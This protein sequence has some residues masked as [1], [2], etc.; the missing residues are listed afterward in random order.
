M[1][2]SSKPFLL[3]KTFGIF[4]IFPNEYQNRTILLKMTD[5]KKHIKAYLKKNLLSK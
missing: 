1:T 5:F 3:Y 4:E 2:L